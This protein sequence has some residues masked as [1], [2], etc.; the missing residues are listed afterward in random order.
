[1]TLQQFDSFPSAMFRFPPV[2]YP[3]SAVHRIG[4][5]TSRQ[6]GAV[7]TEHGWRKLLAVNVLQNQSGEWHA[8]ELLGDCTL[9]S[10]RTVAK[11][12]VNSAWIVAASCNF[13]L[14]FTCS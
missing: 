5:R 13:L 8:Y 6:R 4:A 3:R 9:M 10:P 11:M 2:F 1:M 7:L 14:P 12:G